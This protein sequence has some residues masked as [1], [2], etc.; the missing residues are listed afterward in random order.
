M[1][2]RSQCCDP[3]PSPYQCTVPLTLLQCIKDFQVGYKFK[4]KNV[5]YLDIW[6]CID[7]PYSQFSLSLEFLHIHYFERFASYLVH[8][9]LL[10]YNRNNKTKVKSIEHSCL[11]AVEKKTL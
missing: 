3:P 2:Q 9:F 11:V 10:F 6:I 5:I 7:Y 4:K 8:I 1:G